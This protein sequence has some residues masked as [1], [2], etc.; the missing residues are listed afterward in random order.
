MPPLVLLYSRCVLTVITDPV[1]CTPGTCCVY[2]LSA[3]HC[4]HDVAA[5]TG[6]FCQAVAAGSIHA[7]DISENVINTNLLGNTT[8]EMLNLC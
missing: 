7:S 1:E 4:G 5:A 8:D 2:F 6:Q 3:E